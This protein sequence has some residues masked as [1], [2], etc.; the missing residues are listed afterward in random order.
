MSVA[1]TL[2][3]IDD[4]ALALAAEALGTRTKKDTVNAA[5]AEVVARVRREQALDDLVAM[6][7]DGVFDRAVGPRTGRE[8]ERTWDGQQR[9]AS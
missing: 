8:G 5:L 4:E 3:D 1:K 9:T 6:A 7:E 2:V